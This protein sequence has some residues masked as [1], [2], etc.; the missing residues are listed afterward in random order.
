MSLS[1]IILCSFEK[2]FYQILSFFS[3]AFNVTIFTL[4]FQKRATATSKANGNVWVFGLED[5]TLLNYR[6]KGCRSNVVN[7]RLLRGF[8]CLRFDRLDEI[9]VSTASKV[10]KIMA[11]FDLSKWL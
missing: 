5:F 3:G 4:P 2:R 9:F 8:S 1:T 7:G 10:S 11:S 6:I